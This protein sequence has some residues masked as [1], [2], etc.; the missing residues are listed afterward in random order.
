MDTIHETLLY[1]IQWPSYMIVLSRVQA[2][3]PQLKSANE[4]LSKA[5][6]SKLNIENLEDEDERYI[7]MVLFR[8]SGLT[9][10]DDAYNAL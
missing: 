5:D 9:S 4:E 7:E 3:L 8:Q 2:F 6:P 1:D 10:I